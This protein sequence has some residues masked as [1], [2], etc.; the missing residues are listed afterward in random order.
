M[1]KNWK[2]KAA[3]RVNSAVAIVALSVAMATSAAAQDTT[4]PEADTVEDEGIIVTG[5][6]VAAQEASVEAKRNAPNL[7]D[8][9]AA[10]SV[11]RFPDQN[12]A[13]ALSR[14]PAVGVQR[15]QGQERYI[16]VRGA[17]NRWTSVS[18]D[19][20][21]LIGVDEG[22]DT[23]AF[24]FDA[25]PAVILSQ[26]AINKSLTSD[27]QADAIVANV[28]LQIYSPLGKQG[29]HV[30]GDVGYGFMDLGK[31]EQRQGSLRIS[32]ADENFG[33]VAGA[34]HYRR[35]QLTDNREVGLY[36]APSS[37]ADT[38]FGPTEVDIRQYE[39]ERWN[40]GLFAGLEY[41]PVAGQRIYLSSI[42]TE[43]N[44]DEQRNQYELR[45][46]RAASGFRNLA[47]GDLVN[48]PF[49][50]SFNYGEYRNRNFINT[51]G[52]EHKG[53]DGLTVALKLNYTRTENSSYL[54]L[55]QASTTGLNSPSITY[56][57][58]NP[59]FPIVTLY[60]TLAG[61]TPGTFVRGPLLATAPQ[62]NLTAAGAIMIG[63]LQDTVSDSYTGRFDVS[64]E[65]GDITLSGGA[66]LA[67]RTIRGN[68]FSFSNVAAVGALGGTVGLPFNVNSY[69]TNRP[70][71]TGFPL[72]FTLNYVDNR[73]MRSDIDTLLAALQA[74]GRFNPANNI[75]NIDRYAQDEKIYSGYVMAKAELG[76]ATVVGGVRVEHY[77]LDNSG[78]VRVGTV[79]TPLAV[80]TSYT[81][82]FPSVNAKFDLTEDLV[83]RLAGQRGIS[84]P[85]YGAIRVGS[86]INDTASPG[87][88][89]GG[90][91][92]LQPEK[93]WGVDGSIEYYLPGKG[94]ISVAGFY[95]WVDN[96]LYQS[97]QQVGSD[98]FNFGGRDRSGY[99]LTS[100]FNGE[101]GKLYGIEFNFQQQFTFLPSP[102]DGLGFQGNLTLLEGEYD[103]QLV[104]GVRQTGLAFQGLSD[105]LANASLYYEKYGLSARVSYQWRSDWLDTLGGLGSGEF[106]QRY[107]NLDVSIRYQLTE[108][109]T[110]FADLSNLTNEKYI[111]YQ[112][113]R[114]QPSE[115]EQ[116][117]SR[118][119]FGIRFNY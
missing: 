16:Q 81:D 85:A 119:L 95:R 103:T 67:D 99:L 58:S 55:V 13:A 82:F 79:E 76:N 32:W 50:G 106:R 44:D 36:D 51:I 48:V 108:N 70:W 53:D 87:T 20:I 25:I 75:P 101:N 113:N 90:N 38:T 78:F 65:L 12:S 26:L 17:P 28:D 4:A 89:G 97:Q 40:N 118:Y 117:G 74:A 3:L 105:K 39:I 9:A 15:D 49:R 68:N 114:E 91:P 45:L 37:A 112:D 29:F 6:I 60:Q 42:F 11:G 52:G 94:L 47:S 23:R 84:R 69:V 24:R 34:S 31:G 41:E 21:P 66:M 72:G 92:G 1:K 46:D 71:V 80:R 57:R 107:E 98:V 7:V 56:D 115:V 5:S 18:L 116:I 35:K 73:A 100:T 2:T 27:I 33:V 22:G 64:K 19:G 83:F 96:V 110:L 102:F 59:L 86:S 63:A 8:V 10:D 14:L 62:T 111:A 54:P 43:F 104:N 88:I 61:P 109:F 93:T 30:T 77:K